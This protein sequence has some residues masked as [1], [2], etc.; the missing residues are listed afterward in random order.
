VRGGREATGLRV[1]DDALCLLGGN[2]VPR[3]GDQSLF[4][5]GFPGLLFFTALMGI[6]CGGGTAAAPSRGGAIPTTFLAPEEAFAIMDAFVRWRGG[7]C[8]DN[9]GGNV[10]ALTACKSRQW[11]ARREWEGGGGFELRDFKVW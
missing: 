2:D 4:K 10:L 11:T 9:G 7:F 3:R 1:N 6:A 8:V 5:N